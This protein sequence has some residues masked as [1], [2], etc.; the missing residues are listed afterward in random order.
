MIT[1]VILVILL[2]LVIGELTPPIVP[3]YNI[4][5][6]VWPKPALMQLTDNWMELDPGSFAVSTRAT[7]HLLNKAIDRYSH[8]F[9]HY[10]IHESENTNRGKKMDRFTKKFSALP[11][12]NLVIDVASTPERDQVQFGINESYTLDIRGWDFFEPKKLI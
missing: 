1:T 5:G 2:N 4:G 8:L 6:F 7:N 10:R 3:D 12:N 9:F 11:Q